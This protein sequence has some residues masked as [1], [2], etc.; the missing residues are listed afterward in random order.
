MSSWPSL[1]K[2]SDDQ[3]K[4]YRSTPLSLGYSPSQLLMGRTL[5]STVPM[6]RSQREP[7]IPDLTSVRA[8]DEKNKARQKQNHEQPPWCS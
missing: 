1:L 5:R 2:K 3:Y 4:A 6:T 8:R 7:R